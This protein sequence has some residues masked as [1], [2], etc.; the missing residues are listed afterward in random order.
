MFEQV[1]P[2]LGL[3]FDLLDYLLHF[4]HRSICYLLGH[5]SLGLLLDLF[6]LLFDYAFLDFLPAGHFIVVKLKILIAKPPPILKF[7]L[8]LA[9]LEAICILL[10]QTRFL[11]IIKSL[12]IVVNDGLIVFADSDVFLLPQ[13]DHLVGVGVHISQFLYCKEI[14]HFFMKVKFLDISM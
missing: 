2:N 12:I 7:V 8:H 14:V 3:H 13:I 6:D 1:D 11:S 10:L 4:L 5:A 9:W